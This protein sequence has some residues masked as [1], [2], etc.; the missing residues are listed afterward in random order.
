M[1][2]T[3]IILLCALLSAFPPLST[4]MYLPAIPLLQKAW[5]QPL[6]VLNLT[7]VLFF[8]SYCIFILVYGPLSDRFG[9]RPPLLAGIGVYI[10]ASLVCAFSDQVAS[11]IL[12]R[13][14]QAAGAASASVLAL[15]IA[16]D[17]FE[18][19]ER[20]RI[21]AII[22]IIMALAP[23]LAPSIGSIV[24]KWFSWRLIFASQAMIGIIAWAGVFKMPESLSKK[25]NTNLIQTLGIYLTVLKNR[26]FSGLALLMSLVAL[27]H[28]AFIGGSADIYITGFGM[29]EQS[30]GYFF[31]ANAAALMAGSITCSKVISFVDAKHLL[32][33]SFIGILAGGMAM[34]LHL[35]P[36]PWGLGLPMALASFSFGL[37]RPPSNNLIL[38]QVDQYA[39]SASS[40]MVF[41]YFMMG[42][43]AMWFISFGWTDKIQIIGILGI[44]CSSIV[45]GIWLFIPK[46][47]LK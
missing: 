47:L 33:V 3:S 32:T 34:A 29:S 37:S 41:I 14:F 25:S 46:N 38:E 12:F 27:P 6:T 21:L 23:M 17:V 9:R 22:G 45:L 7:L 19:H 30:F 42:A 31:A 2:K 11:L 5:N 35:V 44:I 18:G 4:D 43:F 8:V 20:V 28:F 24:M 13:I 39:G 26:R 16:K 10:I 40:L 1:K 36:G 15:A